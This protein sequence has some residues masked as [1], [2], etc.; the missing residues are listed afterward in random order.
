[1]PMK[2]DDGP[3]CELTDETSGI[4]C[5]ILQ[6]AFSE[7][8]GSFGVGLETVWMTDDCLR[9]YL[10]TDWMTGGSFRKDLAADWMT[11]GSFRKDVATV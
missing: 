7:C 10:T 9:K 2:S 11:G 4:C 8:G 1:M 3:V 6:V 5:N